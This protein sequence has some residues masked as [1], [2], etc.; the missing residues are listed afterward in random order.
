MGVG[1]DLEHDFEDA[2]GDGWSPVNDGG[3]YDC[4]DADPDVNPGMAEACDG[5]DNDCDGDTDEGLEEHDYCID[6]DGDGVPDL[7]HDSIHDCARPEG[8]VVCDESVEPQHDCDDED[9][10]VFPGNVEICDGLDNDCDGDEDCDDDG[11]D[12]LDGDGWCVCEDCDDLDPAV[13][14]TAEELCDGLDTDCD[15]DTPT[16]EQDVDGDGYLACDADCDDTNDE[17]Y[18]G[19]PEWC[20]GVDNDCD[21]LV[22]DDDLGDS[23]GDGVGDCSDCDAAN[24]NAYPGN[25]E[26]C[27]GVDNDCDGLA[28]DADPDIPDEDGDG[29]SACTDC[30]DHDASVHPGNLEA[31]TNGLD[32]DCDSYVDAYDSSC[33]AVHTDVTVFEHALMETST[34]EEDSVSFPYEAAN[35]WILNLV[36]NDV[37][38]TTHGY[39]FVRTVESVYEEPALSPTD[40]VIETTPGHLVDYLEYAEFAIAIDRGQGAAAKAGADLSVGGPSEAALTAE[41]DGISVAAELGGGYEIDLEITQGS[42]TFD[43]DFDGYWNSE[44]ILSEFWLEASGHFD[45]S[46]TAELSVSEYV[47]GSATVDL[48]QVRGAPIPIGGLITV[49]PM[50]D[51]YATIEGTID[52]EA[53]VTVEAIAEADATL[54]IEW[55]DANSEWVYTGG[56]DFELELIGPEIDNDLSASLRVSVGAKVSVLIMEIAAPYVKVEPY[57][58][59]G[60]EIDDGCVW[61]ADLR[62]AGYIGV[63]IT[64]F[65]YINL[66]TTGP[67]EI[68]D[69]SGCWLFAGDPPMFEGYC[70]CDWYYPDADGDSYGETGAIPVY[71]CAPVSYSCMG[72][73]SPQV[74]DDTDCDDNDADLSPGRGEDCFDNTDNDCDG[75]IDEQDDDCYDPPAIC[76]N[77]VDDD[78]DWWIDLA[79]PGCDDDPNGPDEG[80]YGQSSCN[81]GLDNDQDGAI[82]IDDPDCVAATDSEG[83]PPSCGLGAYFECFGGD[84]WVFESDDSPCELYQ[85]CSCG[86][87]QLACL[88]EECTPG[89]EYCDVND[90]VECSFD[91]CELTYTSCDHGCYADSACC[92]DPGA[93]ETGDLE[94]QPFIDGDTTSYGDCD[95][96]SDVPDPISTTLDNYD[97]DGDTDHYEFYVNDRGCTMEPLIELSSIS[98]EVDAVLCAKLTRDD[99]IPYD[100]SGCSSPNVW[101][102]SEWCCVDEGGHGDGEVLDLGALGDLADNS[103]WLTI[104]VGGESATDHD[105]TMFYDLEVVHF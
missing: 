4:D 63:D 40:I 61:D 20:D 91:G 49:A 62:A 79:D 46:I 76:D 55:D 10:R 84:V 54:R 81:D 13:H 19:H 96:W 88:E 27:D 95:L 36:Q 98:N 68:F 72:W 28:D 65:G 59:Y 41:L 87:D 53:T 92:P 103:G 97:D 93:Y 102:G 56:H 73:A 16:T 66:V 39:G 23:D 7:T 86:C 69:V 18:P 82:D 6:G 31:C 12:D 15:G 32:D 34:L 24:P 104:R 51:V 64:L 8:Y 99:G 67:L 3:R 1:V 42:L 35:M 2:D 25:E 80:G 9:P 17:V 29:S 37:I 58:E 74:P 50:L 30:D 100:G 70:G 78:G 43:P 14:P 94:T 47:S 5:I 57:F 26:I 52:A 89:D 83:M 38:A 105:C 71:T 21:G 85:P 90:L 11:V 101:V 75:L 44:E 48:Y 22:D 60:I 33:V 45:A 77:G